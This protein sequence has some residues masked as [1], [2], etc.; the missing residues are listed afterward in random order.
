[1]KKIAMVFLVTI[2]TVASGFCETKSEP[3]ARLFFDYSFAQTNIELQE[4]YLMWDELESAITNNAGFNIEFPISRCVYLETGI[5]LN[6]VHSKVKI[7]TEYDGIVYP[8]GLDEPGES[9]LVKYDGDALL[10]YIFLALPL[11]GKI[12]HKKTGLYLVAGVQ[13]G[14]L[15]KA[16]YDGEYHMSQTVSGDSYSYKHQFDEDIK[17]DSENI[18]FSYLLGAGIEI[19]VGNLPCF[20]QVIYDHGLTDLEKRQ[21]YPEL[22]TKMLNFGFGFF[23][24]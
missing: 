23:F 15:L 5:R 18:N 2:F 10:K 24:N 7:D 12:K 11:K 9:I 8:N 20:A 4:S 22:K 17:S 6:S 14:Y 3:A 21:S 16:S 1:M 13:A 19:N